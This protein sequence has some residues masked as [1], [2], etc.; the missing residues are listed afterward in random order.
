MKSIVVA[1]GCRYSM[2]F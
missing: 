1:V 2:T